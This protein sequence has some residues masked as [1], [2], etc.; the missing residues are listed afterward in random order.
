MALRSRLIASPEEVIHI[1]DESPSDFEDSDC[2][3]SET[4]DSYLED[5]AAS[6]DKLDDD[7]GDIVSKTSQQILLDNPDQYIRNASKEPT[8][9]FVS[10]QS[11]FLPYNPTTVYNGT[12]TLS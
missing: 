7:E 5:I 11:D 1:L 12:E 6:D 2:S 9:Q 10:D 3:S 8:V 4:S